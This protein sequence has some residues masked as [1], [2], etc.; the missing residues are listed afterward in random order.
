MSLNQWQF[1]TQTYIFKGDQ[2]T[3]GE[4]GIDGDDGDKGPKGDVGAPGVRGPQ[5]P[6]VS[7]H[8]MLS[9]HWITQ[10]TFLN[11]IIN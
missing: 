5:G 9:V 7:F 3:I 11:V 2:G 6:P 10:F 1:K 8:I 4:T